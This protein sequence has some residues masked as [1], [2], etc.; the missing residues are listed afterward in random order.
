MTTFFP[1]FSFLSS[2]FFPS[3]YVLG[4]TLRYTLNGARPSITSPIVPSK[5]IVIAWPGPILQIN[6]RGFKANMLPSITNG[7]FMPLNYGFGRMA[8]NS[9]IVGP[10]NEICGKGIAGNIDAFN[11]TDGSGSGWSIDYL[12]GQGGKSEPVV[13]RISIDGEVV[14]ACVSNENR[15]D[16]VAAN[17]AP[18]PFHGFSFVLSKEARVKLMTEGDH[19]LEVVAVGSPSSV[20]PTGLSEKGSVVCRSG[21]CLIV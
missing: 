14:D 4:A 8:L 17:V 10:N 19:R 15:P 2:S 9:Q 12:A 16:L 7:A 21:S 5:G 6:V 18:D 3:L 11:S 20:V 13:L 1:F